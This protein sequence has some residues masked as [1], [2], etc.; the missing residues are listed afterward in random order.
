VKVSDQT[1]PVIKLKGLPVQTMVQG[2]AFVDA[3]SIVTDNYSTGLTATVT[4]K[5][6]TAV[7]G[8]YILTYNAKDAA[9]NAATPVTRTV[10]VIVGTVVQ[11][12]AALKVGQPAKAKVFFASA[13]TNTPNDLAASLGFCRSTFAQVANDPVLRTLLTKFTIDNG[14]TLPTSAQITLQM[15]GGTKLP[16]I[17]WAKTSAQLVKTSVNATLLQDP[18][19]D[20]VIKQVTACINSFETIKASNFKTQVITLG[21]TVRTWDRTDLN[22][23]L[24]IFYKVRG[25]INWARSYNWST[26]VDADGIPDT[27][28]VS[29]VNPVDNYT[30]QYRTVNVAPVKV[31][32]NPAFFTLS[33]GGSA[34]LTSSINDF[35][36]WAYTQ[37]AFLN[38]M[39]ANPAR[40][41]NASHAFNYSSNRIKLDSDLTN[42]RK[43]AAAFSASGYLATGQVTKINTITSGVISGQRL[44]ALT[45]AAFPKFSYDV[46]P[47]LALSKQYDS[48]VISLTGNPW[49]PTVTANILIDRSYDPT[50]GGVLGAGMTADLFDNI[51]RPLVSTLLKDSYSNTLMNNNNGTHLVTDGTTAVLLTYNWWR[52]LPISICTVNA[53]T[54]QC[55]APLNVQG[56][57][58]ILG[59]SMINGKLRIG[60]VSS[61]ATYIVDPAKGV[62]LQTIPWIG[63]ASLNGTVNFTSDGVNDYVFTSNWGQIPNSFNWGYTTTMYQAPVATGGFIAP[64]VVLPVPI[65]EPSVSAGVIYAL[66]AWGYGNEQLI[67]IDVATMTKKVADWSFLINKLFAPTVVGNKVFDVNSSVMYEYA[68][69]ANAEFR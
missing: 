35:Y 28:V 14:A 25:G 50:I 36:S 41:I 27:Q 46:V 20:T 18:A 54:G 29:F 62:I 60:S 24:S 49:I 31:L 9:G 3:G 11:G 26:D 32:N 48:P 15:M 19:F 30:Y 17:N 40:A 58:N 55:T 1:A 51:R 6:N 16:A 42:S 64:P 59:A 2:S 52:N 57:T 13:Q 68:L 34:L 8:S 12:N 10:N 38:D 53:A 69:P 65:R 45:R 66:P 22:G 44:T 61:M 33:G 7:L 21:A 39:Y 43:V 4:R 37:V 67:K 5:V 23:M 47:N 56:I 63:L